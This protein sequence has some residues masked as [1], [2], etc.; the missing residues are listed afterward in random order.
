MKY[1]NILYKY[2]TSTTLVG[3][4]TTKI[5]HKVA[6]TILLKFTTKLPLNKSLAKMRT[7]IRSTKKCFVYCKHSYIMITKLLGLNVHLWFNWQCRYDLCFTATFFIGFNFS[8]AL[9]GTHK[10]CLIKEVVKL[11]S[12]IQY[13]ELCHNKQHMPYAFNVK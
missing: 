5:H 3:F 4:T 7:I 13:L 9:S 1:L 11:S 10:F 2:S 12:V 6:F 8:S